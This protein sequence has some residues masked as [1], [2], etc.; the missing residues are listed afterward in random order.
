MSL[1]DVDDHYIKKMTEI[2]IEYDEFMTLSHIKQHATIGV[3]W[4]VISHGN[5]LLSL[6]VHG[7][8]T[9]SELTT[10]IHRTAPTTTTLVKKL[11]KEGLVISRKSDSDNR[12]NLVSLADKGRQH[13]DTMEAYVEKFYDVAG[14]GI[15]E[16]EAE[17][18]RNILVK[19]MNNIKT[20]MQEE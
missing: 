1:I 12:V 4:M 11:K 13:C 14:L 15:T 5:I 19:S 10:K 17:T 18:V 3:P 20:G 6:L 16:E 8:L 9:M 2:I 7:E